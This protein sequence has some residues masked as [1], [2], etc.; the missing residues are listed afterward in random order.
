MSTLASTTAYPH[1]NFIPV[2][3]DPITC[4]AVVKARSYTQRPQYMTNLKQF[5]LKKA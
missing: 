5:N 1:E 2:L 3:V 4:V